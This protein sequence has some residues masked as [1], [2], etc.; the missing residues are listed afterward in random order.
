MSNRG[1]HH[2]KKKDWIYDILTEGEIQ[3]LLSGQ[4]WAGN[5]PDIEVFKKDPYAPE[6]CGGFCFRA[7]DECKNV[8][9]G[10]TMHIADKIYDYKQKMCI[11]NMLN[12]NI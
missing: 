3:W 4:K 6:R 10:F 7:Y 8:L 9:F 5:S 2:K 12:I 11:R 1:R